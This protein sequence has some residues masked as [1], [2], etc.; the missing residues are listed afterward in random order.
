MNKPAR[1]AARYLGIGC[2]VIPCHADKIAAYEW[3][4]Y[5]TR[6][7]D[8]A[9][10]QRWQQSG[11][12]AD[13]F[14]I[15]T[16]YISNLWV[17][18]CDNQITL[19][20]FQSR[21]PHI[22]SNTRRVKT[23]RGEHIYL[24]GT[25]LKTARF[26]G[27]DIQGNGTYVIGPFSVIDG[28][29]Y[30][31]TGPGLPYRVNDREASEIQAWAAQFREE[32]ISK[33]ADQ[34]ESKQLNFN[35][36]RSMALNHY[37]QQQA[38]TGSRNQALFDTAL[39]VRDC[40]RPIE[41]AVE[42]LMHHHIEQPKEGTL[43]TAQKRAKEALATISSAYSRDAR[44]AT[45][46]TQIGL[47]NAIREHF[48][49]HGQAGIVRT[50]DAARLA[51]IHPGHTFNAKQLLAALRGIVGRNTVYLA[52]Q[53]QIFPLINPLAAD[54]AD[55][56]KPA[57]EY[58]YMHICN[59]GQNREKILDKRAA[60][61]RG[62][63][64]TIYIMPSN[65]D[66]FDSLHIDF[67]LYSDALTLDDCAS[68]KLYR[69]ALHK[70]LIARR[71]GIYSQQWLANIRGVSTRT[72]RRYNQLCGI[73]SEDVLIETPIHLDNLDLVPQKQRYGLFLLISGK[74]KPAVRGLA[75][76]A[77]KQNKRVSMM[78][79]RY[80][81]YWVGPLKP[82]AFVTGKHLAP[83]VSPVE[84][85][86][87]R[88]VEQ[89][90]R[91]SSMAADKSL[92][93]PVQPVSDV[94]TMP[95]LPCYSIA[96]K[97][98]RATDRAYRNQERKYRNPLNDSRLEAIS[99]RIYGQIGSIRLTTARQVASICTSEMIQH[100]LSVVSKYKQH[101][102]IENQAGLFLT[103]CGYSAQQRQRQG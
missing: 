86:A 92:P 22:Y 19:N 84:Q 85:A 78:T 49:Q 72:I 77:L 101:G 89:K 83:F 54:A 29:E 42:I 15:V 76:I 97:R 52:L 51:G 62:R 67:S 68:I 90:E 1:S 71:P 60:P 3:K 81:Y 25:P 45:Q 65:A 95:T 91:I 58:K 46:K 24:T 10:M 34:V 64:E 9:Q 40:H 59:V 87:W 11:A 100:G 80:K 13:A 44:P 93:A 66:L 50:V 74:T 38:L 23:R 98:N 96:P 20:S 103:A 7:A 36:T 88:E 26:A 4:Q 73:Q 99:Q 33:R 12:F 63:P 47:P 79:K 56:E 102:N 43:E 70:A 18:D 69:A 53:A 5:Q 94:P 82:Y 31:P 17:V 39:W 41:W 27:V 28:H 2:S 6:R 30:Q 75:E 21:F 48:F 8:D 37:R 32:T 35:L 16:G 14:G 57:T 61:S 55:A